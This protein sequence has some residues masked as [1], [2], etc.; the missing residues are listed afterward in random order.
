MQ[1][2]E[3]GLLAVQSDDFYYAFVLGTNAQGEAVLRV[4]RRQGDKEAVEGVVCLL[5]TSRCV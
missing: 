1:G 4:Y 5:Y 3:A 2:E